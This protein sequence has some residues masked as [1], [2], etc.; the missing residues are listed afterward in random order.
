[1]AIK[2]PKFLT[3]T[4]AKSRVF[5]IF[6]VI[7][8][9]AAAVFFGSR[10]LSGP[11]PTT[12][13]RV[14]AAPSGLQSVPGGQLSPEYYRA[15][16]Q[17]NVQS[18]QQ[19]QISGG[20]AV[21]TLVNIPGA[22][23][24]FPQQQNCTILCPS[25][26][27]VDV[28][29]DIADLVKAGKLPQKDADM[30]LAMAKN[31]VPID[32]YA[33]AL[34]ELVRQ[35]KLTPE[36][37]RQ[38][39]EKYK[40]QHQ[41]ALANESAATM[42]TMIKAGKLP[43]DVANQLLALQ[44]SGISPSDYAAELDRLVKEGKISPETAA[45]LLAQYTQQQAR[46][47]TK[48]GIFQLKQLAKAGAITPDVANELAAMQAK[49]VSVDDYAAEL[50]RL[51]AAGKLT[52]AEAAKLLA[53]YKAKRARLGS[54][55]ALDAL[56]KQAEI[57]CKK[58]LEAQKS[59]GGSQTL[60]PSC[61]KLNDLKA[62][63]Q[64]L[65]EMQGN[66]ASTSDYANEL[67]RAVQAGL[68]SPDDAAKLMQDY[69]A[70]SGSVVAGGPTVETTLPGTADFAKLQQAVQAQPTPVAVAASSQTQFTQ[71]LDQSDQQALQERQQRIQQLQT[72]M[73]GQAQTLLTA[74]QPPKMVHVAGTPPVTKSTST[75]T[76]VSGSQSGGASGIGGASS[77][78]TG[79]PL[80]KAGTIMFGVL[81][82][83]VDSD[84]P[85]TPVMVTIVQGKFKGAR[86]IG[87]L[88][89]ATGMDR[90]SLNFN[91]MDR[92][93]WPKSKTVNAFAMDPDTAR[94]VL[95]SNV[96]YHYLK[97]YGAL[98]A[99]SF[100]QGYAQGI[101][102]AGTATTGIFGTSTTHPQLSPGNNIAVALGQVGTAF[103]AA[104]QDYI[105]T[106]T[107]VKVTAGVGL[108][109]LFMG[110]VTQ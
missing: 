50:Q 83:A 58:D 30:L 32:E 48:E 22:Q 27:K 39:L 13:S 51:V 82:T 97:R 31:N 94:T 16:M 109:I 89:L 4:D 9:V 72:A 77:A 59:A 49:N 78:S 60:P 102:N 34:D 90:V 10:Y 105:N 56:I 45:A 38:L 87:K 54:A 37:A 84:Y 20:S 73:S 35:G 47:A 64:R 103:T 61:Q 44:K 69:A 62:E 79:A 41:N 8:G 33:A 70:M 57:E 86:L 18:S 40:K 100:M 43:L 76:T 85:D 1:M 23:S 74:W 88:A 25:E 93:D 7:V 28:A 29:S 107:T 67:K 53:D 26:D 110:D 91:L 106:P 2:L 63:A 14:A 99:S 108:G 21:P 46:E 68:L 55:G 3:S 65:A 52:P 98:F 15:L 75:T 17:A 36:Q 5:L 96:D 42:D 81:D 71:A 104:V 66:N 95:A 92:D 101:T 80:I 24:Q 19:A 11:A 12:A 6:L